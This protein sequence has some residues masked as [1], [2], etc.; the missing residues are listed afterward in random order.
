[1]YQRRTRLLKHA[2]SHVVADGRKLTQKGLQR[3]PF[4]NEIKKVLD[5]HACAVENGDATL[6]FRVNIDKEL[7]HGI[8]SG[9]DQ[10][11]VYRDQSTGGC[12]VAR[13]SGLRL[14]RWLQLATTV[15]GNRLANERLE[16]GLVDFSALKD[17][18]RPARVAVK[19]RIEETG[20]VFQRRAFGEGQLYL[21]FVGFARAG[22]GC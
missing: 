3:I 18:N 11:A 16:G 9:D 21:V 5:W 6:D 2:D 19:A 7:S 8:L 14:L 20:R 12:W 22:K 10:S 13:L 1:M 4:L 15:E 17:V